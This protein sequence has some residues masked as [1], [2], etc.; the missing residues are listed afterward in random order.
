MSVYKLRDRWIADFYIGG[1]L[2]KRV[3]RAFKLK[4]HAETF[5][6]NEKLKEFKGE[7]GAKHVK[8]V[9][10]KPFIEKY[11]ELH[12]PT[13][14]QSSRKRDEYT[15]S[16][17]LKFFGNPLLKQFSVEAIESFKA[18]RAKRVQVTT[19][20]KE[21]DLLKS[22]LNRAVDWGYLRINPATRV[23]KFKENVKEPVFL[24]HSEGSRL[25]G[26]A[27][28]QIRTMIVLGL[29]SGL[30]KTE[31]FNL[32]WE[33]IDFVEK[34]LRVRI[35]KGKSFRMIPMNDLLCGILMSHPRHKSSLF[36]LHNS[37]GSR[38]KDVRWSFQKAL[39][40]AGLPQ[41]TFHSLRHSFVTNLVA[42]GVDLRVVQELAGHKDLRTTMRY[43]H[44]TPN[45]LTDSVKKLSWQ[46]D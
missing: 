23:K 27:K 8:D 32:R 41:K 44:L 26:V 4:E 19:V 13:K 20:N 31:M 28:G 30:R 1:R 25:I 6:R 17:I 35:A 36:I 5:E 34:Q 7:I 9:C 22:I 10:L 40:G 3:R 42:N 43:A 46:T 18:F 11:R 38:W 37:D 12:S 21:L 45:R 24:N 16:H 14:S 2:G 29:C 33:D 15:F 39:K